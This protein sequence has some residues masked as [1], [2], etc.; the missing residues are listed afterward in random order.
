MT[1]STINS[2]SYRIEYTDVPATERGYFIGLKMPGYIGLR[3][4]DKM[5]AKMDLSIVRG[6]ANHH[7][8]ILWDDCDDA[9]RMA[10]KVEKYITEHETDGA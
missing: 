7:G 4:T 1:K 8:V 9:K 2:L 5:A 3:V 10:V 6:K